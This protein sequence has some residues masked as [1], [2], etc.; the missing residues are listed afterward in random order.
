MTGLT[1]RSRDAEQGEKAQQEKLLVALD[2]SPSQL[3]R[4]QCGWWEIAG[5][6]G[7]IQTFGDGATCVAHIVCRSARHWTHTKRRLGFM[8][9]TQ[10]GDDEGCLRF[11]ELPT[12]QQAELIRDILGL[13]KRRDMTPEALAKLEMARANSPVSR[14]R[15]PEATVAGRMV[16]LSPFEPEDT[17]NEANNITTIAEAAE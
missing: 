13:R 12:P 4:D 5:K 9:V 2:A 14:C 15:K 1:Y 10:D 11:H 7:T 3:R 16:P 6:H 17:E 8:K